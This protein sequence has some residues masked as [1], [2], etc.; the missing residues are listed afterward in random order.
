VRWKSREG[1]LANLLFVDCPYTPDVPLQRLKSNLSG[2]IPYTTLPDST[3]IQLGLGLRPGE[4]LALAWSDVQGDLLHVRHSQRREG[5]KLHPRDRLKTVSSIRV[6][7]IPL[8]IAEAIESRRTAQESEVPHPLD[9]VL[10]PKT[11][12][13][14]DLRPTDE[15]SGSYSKGRK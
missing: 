4:V 14:F 12:T 13:P 6:L 3:L 10:R 5:G 11:A 8:V 15:P 2:S 7:Q 9:L 1:D